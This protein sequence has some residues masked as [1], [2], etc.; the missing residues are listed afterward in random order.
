MQTVHDLAVMHL[1]GELAAAVEATRRKI[2]GADN[3]PDSVGKEQ[4]GMKLEPLEPV[5]LDTHIVQNSQAPD[6]LDEF[7]LLELVRRPGQHVNFHAA[8]VGPDQALDDDGVLVALV[9]HPQ[10]M[11]GLVDELANALAAIADAPDQM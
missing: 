8:M 10:R 3:G 1:D 9:L 4:F 6:A 2:D 5:H 7:L 11:L